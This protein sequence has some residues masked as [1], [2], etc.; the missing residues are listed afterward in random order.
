MEKK[1]IAVEQRLANLSKQ[2]LC[3]TFS[4]GID[5]TLL[6]FLAKVHPITAIT[7]SSIFQ[8]QEE[9]VFC[10]E[11]CE[12]YAIPHVVIP[13]NPLE[14]PILVHNPKDRCYHCKKVFFEKALSYA[15]KNAITHVLDGTNFDD[16]HTYRPGLLALKELGVHSPF[17]L[18]KITKQEIRLKAKSL[19]LR[20][21][22]KPSNPCFATRFPYGQK[23][24]AD[25]VLL[26]A[27]IENILRQHGF[28]ENR[29]R[30]HADILRIELKP[31]DMK[32]FF[33][34]QV[35]VTADIKKLG[36]RYITLDVEGLRSS[37]DI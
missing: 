6:L 26:V 25:D 31:E 1:F 27:T 10:E 22:N 19:G 2:G 16:M 7:F 29:A 15:K 35:V 12:Q 13:F 37:M 18:E 23:L 5:S 24:T 9:I 30:L 4:G 36:V 34:Q 11:F 28:S 8:S 21:Y 17:A 33:A 3:I 20:M 14:N 32:N